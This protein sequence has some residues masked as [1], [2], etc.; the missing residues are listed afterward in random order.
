VVRDDEKSTKH[1]LPD[2]ADL[3]EFFENSMT[4]FIIT[5]P[6]GVIL[7]A[8]NRFAIWMG[9]QPEE[10]TGQRFSNHLN[11]SGKI[12]LETHL[13]PLLRMQGTFD[14]VALE[15][16]PTNGPRIPVLVNARE[17]RDMSGEP[18]SIA[19]VIF[20]STERHQY[21]TELLTVRNE[22]RELNVNLAQ[23]VQDEVRDR[24]TAEGR[25]NAEQEAAQLREQFIAV[26]GHDLRN[27]LAGIE[28]GLKMVLR[29]QQD[30]KAVSIISLMQKSVERMNALVSNLTD[31]A[32]GRLGGGILLQNQVVQLEPIITHVVAE[33]VAASSSNTVELQVDL[34]EP[35]ECDPMR[36]AQLLSNLVANAISHGETGGLVNVVGTSK[37]SMFEM[38]VSNKGPAIPPEILD[39]LF[40]PFIRNEAG[41]TRLGLG[42]GLYICSE[43]ARAHGG[44]L[45][46]H[47]AA[48]ETKFT[49][50]MPATKVIL[51]AVFTS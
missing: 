23:R 32:R 28:A 18:R 2:K 39:K 35:V 6:Q 14:E 5:D 41:Q 43:I 44:E 46:V 9:V 10:L 30:D 20:K 31:F 50:R 21:E 25:F 1:G 36:I 51:P 19:Y 40:Q 48:D 22:L 24:L 29:T 17:R 42:L 4:G 15:L 11:I 33:I 26:L 7:H 34:P 16:S 27:P 37:G 49:F 45:K 8:N 47:S 3:E 38:S 12:Y 13:A